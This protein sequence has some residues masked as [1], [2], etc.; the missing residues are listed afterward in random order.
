MGDMMRC[1]L[2]GDVGAHIFLSI[3]DH[4]QDRDYLRCPTCALRFLDPAQHPDRATEKAHYD[5]HENDPADDGYRRFLSRLADPL[6]AQLKPGA[7]G[8]DYGCG[9][10]PALA[11]M[12][13]ERGVDMAIY[14]PVYANDAAALTP[15]MPY[16]F[17]TCTETAEHFHDPA[18]EFRRL[19]GLVHRGGHLALMTCF[20]TDDVLF[21]NWHYR[22][23][24]THVAFYREDTFAWIAAAYG[25][26]LDIPRKDVAIFTCGTA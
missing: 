14:D 12:L 24:P 18:R 15:A 9:P 19:A 17:I 26:S 10:G 23:D 8:L 5:L 22:K 4:D 6:M 7:L 11:A 2:C 13:R 3:R 20:Q 21:A 25:W 16:D 1:I